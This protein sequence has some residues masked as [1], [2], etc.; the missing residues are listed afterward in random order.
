MI[1]SIILLI[2]LAITAFIFTRKSSKNVPG[3][4]KR[5]NKLGNLADIAEAGKVLNGDFRNVLEQ[6]RI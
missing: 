2:I 6:F 4:K 5:D 3:M 1:G